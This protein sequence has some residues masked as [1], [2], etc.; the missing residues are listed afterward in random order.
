MDDAISYYGTPTETPEAPEEESGW[1][2]ATPIQVGQVFIGMLG[3]V[4]NLACVLVL[5][6]HSVR[7]NTNLLIVNQAIIDCIVSGLLVASTLS[8]VGGIRSVKKSGLAARVYC[9]L[10]NSLVLVFGGFAISTFNLVALSIERY[11]AVLHPIWY[12]QNFKKRA[13]HLLIVS[14]WVLGPIFQVLLVALHYDTTDEGTCRYTP[15]YR[16]ILVMLFFWDYFI[17]ACIMTFSFVAIIR[18]FRQL[19]TVAHGRGAGE[20]KKTNILPIPSTSIQPGTSE[21]PPSSEQPSENSAEPN[22]IV[23]ESDDLP[24]VEAVQQSSSTQLEVPAG[25]NTKKSSTPGEQTKSDSNDAPKPSSSGQ[26]N[27]SGAPARSD[28]DAAGALQR[29]NTTKVLLAMYVI[30]LVCWS[31]NQWT[32]LQYNLGGYVNFSSAWYRFLVIM[33]NLNTCV[34]PFLFA[35]RLKVYRNEARA[36]LRNFLARFSR[37]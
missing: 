1:A 2:V 35:L 37:D 4:G 24:P 31:P 34:N 28:K 9:N 36:M 13:I 20:F 5:R 15:R 22:G 17:P 30:Y 19:N 33:G 14:T 23:T 16:G 3:L 32:F 7:N 12:L 11:V 18:K 8:D 27:T 29:R 26:G 6:R 10:W 21:K 25:I